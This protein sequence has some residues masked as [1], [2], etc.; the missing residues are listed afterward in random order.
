MSMFQELEYNPDI[1]RVAGV[2]F[3]ILSPQETRRRSVA[4]ITTNELYVDDVPKVGGL[5]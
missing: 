1:E 2:Q 4:E 5:S 3:S